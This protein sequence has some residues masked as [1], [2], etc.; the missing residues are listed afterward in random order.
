MSLRSFA[1]FM[2]IGTLLAWAAW[3]LILVNVNPFET[4]L[5]GLSLFYLTLA[6]AIVGTVTLSLAFIR[7][8]IF[9]RSQV[10]SREIRIAFRHAVL[11]TTVA[12]ISLILSAN[13]W[14]RTWHLVAL[15]ALAALA[16]GAFR[17]LQR[18]N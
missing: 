12:L 6:V 16:E 2:A 7:V 11:F 9:R 13:G 5:G 14:V 10:P 18:R 15:V 17:S 3:G 8:V 1:I 4:S